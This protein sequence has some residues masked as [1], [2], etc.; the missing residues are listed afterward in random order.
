MLLAYIRYGLC[1]LAFLVS[2]GHNT[3]CLL[4]E[5]RF[6]PVL[7]DGLFFILTCM[8]DVEIFPHPVQ[9]L[10]APF[11]RCGQAASLIFSRSTPY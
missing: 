10:R 1:Q 11:D 5:N 4:Y 6:K 8:S 7:A 2:S 9:R 3:T